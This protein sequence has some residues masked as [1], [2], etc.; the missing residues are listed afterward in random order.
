[1][2]AVDAMFEDAMEQLD[3]VTEA[4]ADIA[5][6]RARSDFLRRVGK[7]RSR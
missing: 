5:A 4:M 1:M 3:R 2:R 7:E 6:G